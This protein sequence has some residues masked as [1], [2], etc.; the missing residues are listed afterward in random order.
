M[1]FSVRTAGRPAADA[2]AA[3]IALHAFIA[4]IEENSMLITSVR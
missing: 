3:I 4:L 2:A 1:V